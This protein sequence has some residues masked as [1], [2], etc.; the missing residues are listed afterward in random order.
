MRFYR[1]HRYSSSDG[2]FGYEFFVSKTDAE[3]AAREWNADSEGDPAEVDLIEIEPT[4]A[5]ILDALNRYADH[6]NNG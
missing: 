6:P 3:K 4:K 2:S 5:G 1:V